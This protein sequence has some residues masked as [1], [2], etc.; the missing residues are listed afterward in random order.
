MY[1][2]SEEFKKKSER[3]RR[4]RRGTYDVVQSDQG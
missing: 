2:K 3:E 4:I 1:T